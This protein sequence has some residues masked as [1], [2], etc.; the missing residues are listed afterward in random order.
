MAFLCLCAG[1]STLYL[2]PCRMRLSKFTGLALPVACVIGS[3]VLQPYQLQ[4][5]RDFLHPEADP[6]HTGWHALQ[7]KKA[8]SS[9][10]LFGHGWLQTETMVPE[11]H[12]DFILSA[13]AEQFGAVG[14]FA[15]LSCFVFVLHRAVVISRRTEDGFCRFM[16]LGFTG[17][18]C[19]QLAVNVGVMYGLLPIVGFSAPLISYGGSSLVFLLAGFG[20]LSSIQRQQRGGCCCIKTLSAGGCCGIVPLQFGR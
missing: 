8:V 13:V 19:L 4:R 5:F 11:R 20:V 1:W 7:L 10:G 9:G 17:V 2:S 6:Q 12:T 3:F 16:G 15:V 14:M 18:V